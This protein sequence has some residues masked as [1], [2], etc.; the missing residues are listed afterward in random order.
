MNELLDTLNTYLSERRGLL[1]MIGI[2]LIV[3]NFLLQIV[4]NEDVWLASSNLFLHL[5][6][7]ITIIGIL[8]I[9]PLQ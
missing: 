4:L 1:P 8:L 5:G 9:R 3:I 6:L 7:I 2:V